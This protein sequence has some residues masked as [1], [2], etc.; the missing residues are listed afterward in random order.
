MDISSMESDSGNARSL[1]YFPA[2]IYRWMQRGVR[3]RVKSAR[4]LLLTTTGIDSGEPQT[5]AMSY[6]EDGPDLVVIASN[7]GS[8]QHPTWYRN[9]CARPLVSVQ[10]EENLRHVVASTAT[11]SERAHLRV[12]LATEDKQYG[13][14]QRNTAREIPIVLLR[15]TELVSTE[16]HLSCVWGEP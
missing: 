7:Y 9:M 6:F 2:A 12:R 14:Y 4:I 1:S 3:A 5:V 8:D 11:S 16:Q 10:I 13:R 15:P